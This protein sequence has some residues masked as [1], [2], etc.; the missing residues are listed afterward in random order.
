MKLIRTSNNEIINA[1][2]ITKYEIKQYRSMGECLIQTCGDCCYEL[3]TTDDL[4]TC[5]FVYE[6]FIEWLAS[7][8]GQNVF[9][10]RRVLDGIEGVMGNE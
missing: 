8:S 5:R 6:K 1:E 2:R 3:F 4:N 10:F 9:D 7:D